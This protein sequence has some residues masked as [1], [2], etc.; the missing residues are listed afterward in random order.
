MTQHPALSTRLDAD[1][2]LAQ[3][4]RRVRSMRVLLAADGSD[5][6]RIAEAW[7]VRLRWAIPPRVDIL[8]VARPRRL[9]SGV[10]LQTYRDAVRTAV[11]DLRQGDL[12]LALRI[13]NSAGERLQS[14]QLLTRAWARQGDPVSEI[15]AMVR[16][17]APDLLVIGSQ[18]RRGWFS[19]P[20]I[21]SEAIG[22]IEAGVLV[23]RAVEDEDK[24][25][26]KRVAV[27]PNDAGTSWPYAWLSRAGWLSEAEVVTGA[28]EV[29]HDM[30]AESRP[31]L[32]VI[33]RRS[34]SRVTDHIVR[35][36]LASASAVLVLPLPR[37]HDRNQL[38]AP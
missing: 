11:A 25:L 7:I 17:D 10:A 37:G 6:A 24:P 28:P 29:L 4:D 23:T 26:P 2:A 8:C 1:E 31:D 27:V 9:A 19:R 14:A 32:I 5:A 38:P 3:E 22:Q 12:L 35:G 13:A 33:S 34:G 15:S 30:A 36:A 20:D 18:A 21:A 16:A